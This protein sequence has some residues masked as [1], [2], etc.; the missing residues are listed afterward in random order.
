MSE[1]AAT[2][3]TP[4]EHK[5]WLLERAIQLSMFNVQVSKLGPGA[6]NMREDIRANYNWFMDTISKKDGG[7]Q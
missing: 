7:G 3:V 1:D 6:I 4:D 2:M 5:Y